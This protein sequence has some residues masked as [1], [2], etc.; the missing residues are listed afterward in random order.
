MRIQILFLTI[1]LIIVSGCTQTKVFEPVLNTKLVTAKV[2]ASIRRC[3]DKPPTPKL[4]AGVDAHTRKSVA[5]LI[6]KLDHAHANCKANLKAVDKILT[7]QEKRI[8]TF[9]KKTSPET[10]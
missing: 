4:P 5:I 8:K 6:A 3:A 7:A 10:K 2:P 1:F 9:N